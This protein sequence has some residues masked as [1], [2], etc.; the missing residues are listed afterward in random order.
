MFCDVQAVTL[1]LVTRC[2]PNSISRIS[3]VGLLAVFA[4]RLD[5]KLARVAFGLRWLLNPG[6]WSMSLHN[7]SGY[8]ETFALDSQCSRS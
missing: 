7:R 5:S 3:E 6:I 4:A 2:D 1:L 8:N